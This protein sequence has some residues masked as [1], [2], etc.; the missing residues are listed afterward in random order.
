MEMALSLLQGLIHKAV[1]WCGDNTLYVLICV[2]L[3]VY[4]ESPC[5]GPHHTCAQLNLVHK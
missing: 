2:V 3:Q 5:G 1:N 4:L